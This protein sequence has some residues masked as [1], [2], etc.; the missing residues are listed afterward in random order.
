MSAELP[1]KAGDWP[2][3]ARH[4]ALSEANTARDL[5]EDIASIVGSEIIDIP[6]ESRA[7]SQFTKRELAAILLAL[8]GPRE[9]R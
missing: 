2:F 1:E 9:G 8:G 6:E 5:R 3:E 4:T 7:V